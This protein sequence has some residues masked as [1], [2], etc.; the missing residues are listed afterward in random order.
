MGRESIDRLES[1]FTWRSGSWQ[2]SRDEKDHDED[3]KGIVEDV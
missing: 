3:E 2:D 1:S